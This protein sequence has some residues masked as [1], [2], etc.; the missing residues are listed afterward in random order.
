MKERIAAWLENL[1]DTSDVKPVK[2]TIGNKTWEGAVYTQHDEQRFYLVG[3]LPKR[4]GKVCYL[5][6]EVAEIVK[7]WK[8]EWFIGG[9]REGL[10][11]GQKEDHPFGSHWL[12]VPWNIPGDPESKIDDYEDTPHTR[13]YVDLEIG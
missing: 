13:V 5:I 4:Y 7:I 1:L 9:Y 11:P 10:E 6:N 2:V 12:L 8:H 3:K